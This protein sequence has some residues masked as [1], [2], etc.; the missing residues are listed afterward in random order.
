MQALIG[1][2]LKRYNLS[3]GRLQSFPEQ[4]VILTPENLFKSEGQFTLVTQL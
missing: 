3:D 1:R 2:G 4:Q